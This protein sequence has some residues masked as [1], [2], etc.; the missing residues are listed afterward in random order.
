MR[1]AVGEYQSV[2]TE[3]F[4]IRVVSRTE[5]TTI[6]PIESAVFIFCCKALVYPVPYK[7]SLHVFACGDNIKIFLKVS[8]TITHGMCIFAH[9]KRTFYI[10]ARSIFL[11]V[12]HAW[13]H[14]AHNICIFLLARL[15]KLHRTR[16]IALFHPLI[17]FMEHG[18]VS[19]FIA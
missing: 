1:S 3:V 8:G 18:T 12:T 2:R 14:G 17:H 7:S 4:F 5:V 19:T 6:S 13:I 10:R 11:H 9:D 16:S 15:F